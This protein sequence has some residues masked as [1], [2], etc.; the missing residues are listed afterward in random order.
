M[1]PMN[2]QA[3]MPLFLHFEQNSQLVME[4]KLGE[5]LRL[6]LVPL[7]TPDSAPS[8]EKQ[9]IVAKIFGLNIERVFG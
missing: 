7:D 6:F 3:L 8:K 4:N 9:S 1:D 5:K 2:K